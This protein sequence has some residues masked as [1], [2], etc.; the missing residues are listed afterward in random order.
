MTAGLDYS[1][2]VLIALRAGAAEPFILCDRFGPS[3]SQALRDLRR[4][5]YVVDL[6]SG[7]VAITELGRANC[8]TRRVKQR[9]QNG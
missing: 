6:A 5:G 3:Y 2:R 1:M 8:L 4:K 9:P 7:Q